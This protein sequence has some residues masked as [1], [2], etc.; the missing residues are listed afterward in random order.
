MMKK[1][2]PNFEIFWM[3]LQAIR[4]GFYCPNRN[5]IEHVRALSSLCDDHHT[6]DLFLAICKEY[7]WNC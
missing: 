7:R 1:L 4:Y 3:E 5:F 6:D 2:K